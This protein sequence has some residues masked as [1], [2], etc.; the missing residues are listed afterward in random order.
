MRGRMDRY[1]WPAMGA[2][3]PIDEEVRARLLTLFESGTISE[4][5]FARRSGTKQPWLYRYVR[6]NGQATIDE[7]IRLAAVYAGVQAMPLNG[8]ETELV[9][10]WRGL[11]SQDDQEDV[12]AYLRLRARRRQ[13]KE[14]SGPAIETHPVRANKARGKR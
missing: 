7:V 5:E 1:D 14:S 4:A 6:G 9:R 11:K 12:L 3:H 13:S 10:L 2:E 8:E